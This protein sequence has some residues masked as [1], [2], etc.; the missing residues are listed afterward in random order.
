MCVLR[1]MTSRASSRSPSLSA[2]S[3]SFLPAST[4]NFRNTRGPIRDIRKSATE[5]D[6]A[7][8]LEL[9][10]IRDIVVASERVWVATQAGLAV[11]ERADGG[12][13]FTLSAED[14]LADDNLSRF[15]CV[16]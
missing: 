3:T 5:A 1:P 9:D 12:L 7:D 16:N 13:L 14:G 6:V 8:A 4:A 2:R 10:D 11:Y 15:K